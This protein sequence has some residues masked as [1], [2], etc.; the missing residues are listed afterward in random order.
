MLTIS[1]YLIEM[2]SLY[3]TNKILLRMITESE[4][5]MSKEN[6]FPFCFCRALKCLLVVMTFMA[7]G[8]QKVRR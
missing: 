4:C 3:K 1:Y 6:E 2:N 8:K 7:C 5:I